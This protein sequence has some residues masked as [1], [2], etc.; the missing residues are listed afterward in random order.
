MGV[1]TH[2]LSDVHASVLDDDLA[3]CGRLQGNVTGSI[4]IGKE[5]VP[6]EKAQFEIDHVLENEDVVVL[7]ELKGD[8]HDTMSVHQLL[9]PHLFLRSVVE[10][11]E[12]LL[13]YFMTEKNQLNTRTYK[14]RIHL[15]SFG[16]VQG[17]LTATDYNFVKSTEYVIK[18]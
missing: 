1:L 10:D 15:V 12:V 9:L 4:F 2:F 16:E 7:V 6:V 13:V 14:F 17:I 8:F 3:H 18:K 5:R 11:R